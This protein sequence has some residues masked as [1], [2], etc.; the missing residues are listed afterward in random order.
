MLY[1]ATDLSSP[2]QLPALLSLLLLLLLAAAA[3]AQKMH[4]VSVSGAGN[5]FSPDSIKAAA[6]DMVQFQ[7]RAGNHSV[8]QSN[9]DNPCVPIEQSTAGSAAAAAQKGFF[10]GYM[11]VKASQGQDLIPTYTVQIADSKPVW[12]YCSQGKHCQSGMVMVIN[13][14]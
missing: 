5:T 10:S 13:E 12:A 3:G 9:F 11:D 8:V 7:F 4:V 1:H 6:G 14:E 2:R